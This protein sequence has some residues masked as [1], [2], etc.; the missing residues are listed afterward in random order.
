MELL[1][2]YPRSWKSSFVEA[3]WCSSEVACMF[4]IP[5]AQGL[6]PSTRKKKFHGTEYIGQS[7]FI[8]S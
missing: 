2:D 4:N 3:W 1:K 5:K 7:H 8:T 6:I